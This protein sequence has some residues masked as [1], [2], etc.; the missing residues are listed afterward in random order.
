MSLAI[1][2]FFVVSFAQ[3]QSVN[4][5]V[6]IIPKAI[7]IGAI[8]I[9]DATW[10]ANMVVERLVDLGPSFQI[11]PR[12]ASKVIWVDPGKH[13]KF[14]IENRKFSDGSRVQ[15][16][17]VLDSLQRCTRGAEDVG[18][19]A[20]TKIK[21]YEEF[22]SGRSRELAG[23]FSKSE[24]SLEIVTSDPAPLL[25]DDLSHEACGIVKSNAEK[26]TD[27]L[28]GA[29]GTGPYKVRKSSEKEIKLVKN[30]NY[31][32]YGSMKGPDEL[33][34]SATEN[35]GNAKA[36]MP[37]FDLASGSERIETPEYRQYPWSKIGSLQLILN[38][39][40][41]IF[42]NLELRQA[43][44]AGIDLQAFA[45]ELH[46]P[47]S[48]LQ[49]GNIPYGVPGFKQWKGRDTKRAV[50]LLKKNGFTEVKPLVFDLWISKGI[51]TDIEKRIWATEAFA[52][53]PIRINAKEVKLNE[54]WEDFSKGRFHAVRITRYP[55][56]IDAHRMLSVFLSRSKF[57]FGKFNSPACNKL[58]FDALGKFEY[59]ERVI[60]Y[61]QADNCLVNEVGILPLTSIPPGFAYVKKPWKLERNS[62]FSL[63]PY[64]FDQWI[65][66]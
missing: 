3:G 1:L 38:S 30:P 47:E 16:Q 33:T 55:G 15:V 41:E 31:A 20:L 35:F 42:K 23:L 36:L 11:L 18:S 58:V 52:G 32:N 39:E 27:I 66:E 45:K 56:T 7:P 51:D 24:N 9:A 49:A 62:R 25:L 60:A 57:N 10:V 21:G 8:E 34:F 48:H 50:K 17:D 53:L 54:V 2:T 6:K 40:S 64:E 5:P 19:L 12:L 63:N 22:K 28:K 44:Y 46:W 59:D 26:N 29:L 65:K 4:A 13:L 43:L 61:A 14:L 37:Q